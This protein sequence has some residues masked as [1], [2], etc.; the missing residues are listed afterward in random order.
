MLHDE[1]PTETQS[2]RLLRQ[3]R[4][5][6]DRVCDP[7]LEDGVA[8]IVADAERA[9]LRFLPRD[10]AVEALLEL[11]ET[12]HE[13]SLKRLATQLL[14]QPPPAPG[15]YWCVLVGRGPAALRAVPHPL[16]DPL[17]RRQASAAI[18]AHCLERRGLVPSAEGQRSYAVRAHGCN[19][20]TSWAMAL[21][22]LG[23]D[24]KEHTAPDAAQA[25]VRRLSGA[26]LCLSC[27]EEQREVVAMA[28]DELG[29]DQT[30]AVTSAM[31]RV[32]LEHLDKG[33]LLALREP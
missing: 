11:G 16:T 21:D 24:V 22:E 29:L 14:M 33:R 17:A 9:N 3:L 20:C 12:S 4:P 19:L 30:L 2:A 10:E 5:D 6:L 15:K 31:P 23:V 8:V 32:A 27:I 1:R 7:E 18:G 28:V 26:A 25:Q 13:P